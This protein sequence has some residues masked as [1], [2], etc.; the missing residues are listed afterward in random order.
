MTDLFHCAGCDQ[1]ITDPKIMVTLG[2]RSIAK[3]ES[4]DDGKKR[5]INFYPGYAGEYPL[6]GPKCAS[7]LMLDIFTKK[8]QDEDNES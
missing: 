8:E 1:L 4:S 7:L 5:M 3:I 6:C 2:Q